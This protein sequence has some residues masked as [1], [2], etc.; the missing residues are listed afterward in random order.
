MS[1]EK[2]FNNKQLKILQM[3]DSSDKAVIKKDIIFDVPLRLGI[4]GNSGSGKTNF[5]GSIILDPLNQ[6]YKEIWLPENIYVF[7]GSL[8]TDNKIQGIIKALDVPNSNTFD[9]YNDDIVNL[10]YEQIEDMVAKT[11]EKK[12]KQEHSLFIFDD[13]SYSN[14]IR[15]KRNNALARLFLNGRK[16]QCSTI[17]VAQ[18]Y[19]QLLPSIRVNLTGLVMFNMPTSELEMVE[20]DHNFKPNRKS[21]YQMVRNNLKE[22]HDFLIINYSNKYLEM[23]LDKDFKT[24]VD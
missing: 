12:G 4:V 21:F 20:R 15:N 7:S 22:R 23:Y 19:N 18:R 5:L 17:F 9:E 1:K 8:K 14:S 24:I 3:K 13:L 2:K 16:N 6:F 11:T 10:L